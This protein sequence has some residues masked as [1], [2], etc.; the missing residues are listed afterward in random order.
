MYWVAVWASTYVGYQLFW[1][2]PAEHKWAGHRPQLVQIILI[3]C[4]VRSS[5]PSLPF[6]WAYPF[7][8]TGTIFVVPWMAGLLV[9]HG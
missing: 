9:V 2:W 8:A 7:M 4:A 6:R 5:L 3:R 1:L